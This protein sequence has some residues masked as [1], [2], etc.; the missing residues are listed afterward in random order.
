MNISYEN[1]PNLIAP[2]DA[3][4]LAQEA[5]RPDFVQAKVYEPGKVVTVAGTR[6][7]V[8]KAGNLIRE[9]C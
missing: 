4:R 1:G 2:F 7:R 5:K 3:E 9:E 8:G 6:Y